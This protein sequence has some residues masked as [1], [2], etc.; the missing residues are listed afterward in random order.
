VLGVKHR[1]VLVNHRL[2]PFAAHLPRQVG[3]LRGI[4][5]V[6]GRKMLQPE[7]KKLAGRQHIGRVEAE[8]ARQIARLAM[9]QRFYQ[10]GGAHQNRAIA[11][12]QEI[13]NLLLPR[14]EHPRAG[15]AHR[16]SRIPHALDGGPQPV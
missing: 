1:Q 3:H 12:H 13:D 7:R 11:A 6:S 4:Q 16:N 9:P 10:P 14:L 8:I 15:H 2:D 5:I